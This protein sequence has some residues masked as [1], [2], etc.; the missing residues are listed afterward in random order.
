MKKM[1]KR[2]FL[3]TGAVLGAAGLFGTPAFAAGTPR[4]EDF[5]KQDLIN[6]QGEYVLAPLPY[7]YDALEPHIDEQTM[8]LHHDI[9]H[10]GYV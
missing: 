5:L 9:H 2:D 10:N 3:K 7:A 4:T 6:S 1:N 8:R